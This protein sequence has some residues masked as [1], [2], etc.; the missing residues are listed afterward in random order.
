MRA[1]G[2]STH[3]R[4]LVCQFRTVARRERASSAQGRLERVL[5]W[6]AWHLPEDKIPIRVQSEPQRASMATLDQNWPDSRI[7]PIH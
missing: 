2:K 1:I 5:N 7:E 6:H 3:R 4:C